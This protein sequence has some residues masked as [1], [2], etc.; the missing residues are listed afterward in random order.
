M[1]NGKV[2]IM[3]HG[4]R[5]QVVVDTNIF[6]GL[7]TTARPR[8]GFEYV[9]AKVLY[10]EVFGRRLK[11]GQS[12][13][14]K[15]ARAARGFRGV[16]PLLDGPTFRG[17]VS[18]GEFME[19]VLFREQRPEGVGK[20]PAGVI[21]GSVNSLDTWR[22]ELPDPR[23]ALK[24]DLEAQRAFNKNEQAWVDRITYTANE[25]LEFHE[26]TTAGRIDDRVIDHVDDPEVRGAIAWMAERLYGSQFDDEWKTFL[27][28][29]AENCLSPAVGRITALSMHYTLVRSQGLEQPEERFANNFRDLQYAVLASYVGALCT[30]DK[31]LIKACDSVFGDRVRIFDADELFDI[32]DAPNDNTST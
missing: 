22:S 5:L 28:S 20:Q 24:G 15:Q 25:F 30:H 8:E 11:P 23:M 32:P 19:D 1:G 4:Q 31:G 7:K 2:L 14:K 10:A 26:L 3:G 17:L 9:L 13:A 12:A 18:M 6:D 16:R 27:A 21:A 29:S